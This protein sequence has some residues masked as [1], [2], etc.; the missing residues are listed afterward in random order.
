MIT[1]V[2]VSRPSERIARVLLCQTAALAAGMLLAGGCDSSPSSARF[3]V[4]VGFRGAIQIVPHAANG[5]EASTSG[6]VEVYKIPPSGLLKLKGP[7]PFARW[8]Q[9]NAVYDDG[10]PL[11]TDSDLEAAV[12]GTAQ[13]RGGREDAIALWTIAS[14]E[15]GVLWM[16]VGTREEALHA[17]PIDMKP[18][19]RV[20]VD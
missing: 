6:G 9:M 7:G 5:V 20:K 2:M 4:P 16:Y 14:D 15:D 12:D 8:Q 1:S 17:K 11:P 10:T 13:H 3:V 18:G 19:K